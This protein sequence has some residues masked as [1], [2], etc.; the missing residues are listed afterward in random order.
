[1]DPYLLNKLLKWFDDKN[2]DFY[3]Y[4]PSMP[5]MINETALISPIKVDA[6]MDGPEGLNFRERFW[7]WRINM[8]NWE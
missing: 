8:L 1:M 5:V 4:G 3:F 7:K 6:G 2:L